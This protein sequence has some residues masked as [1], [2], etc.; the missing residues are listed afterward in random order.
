MTAGLPGAEMRTLG[1]KAT[2]RAAR[3]VVERLNDPD[4]GTRYRVLA[5]ARAGDPPLIAADELARARSIRR[6]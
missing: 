1:D 6:H 5:P 2:V 4:T 3:Q